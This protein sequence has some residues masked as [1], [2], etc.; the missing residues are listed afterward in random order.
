MD[1]ETKKLVKQL[2]QK[3]FVVKRNVP[4]KKHTFEID[5]D[6]LDEFFSIVN[7]KKL[8]IKEAA[9]EALDAW[10]IRNKKKGS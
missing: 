5:Q 1:N 7:E 2:E 10:N 4:T 6:V 9:S 8:K 3:G